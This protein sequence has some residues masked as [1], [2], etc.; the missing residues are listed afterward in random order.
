MAT[1]NV[2]QDVISGVAETFVAAS[3]G[4][5]ALPNNGKTWLHFKCT[6]GTPVTVTVTAQ[7]ACNQGTLHNAVGTVPA[8]TGDIVMGPFDT[9]RFNNQ[10]GQALITYSGVTGLTVAATTN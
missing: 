5:D 10:N 7:T 9:Y 3:A 2:V 4:G 6:G 8:T 1:L